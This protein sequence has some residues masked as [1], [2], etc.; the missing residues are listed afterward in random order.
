MPRK[1]LNVVG[2]FAGIGGI[3]QGFKNAEFIPLIANEID[4]YAVK[5]YSEFHDH[6]VLHLDIKD[7]NKATILSALQESGLSSNDLEG[8]ILTGGFPCQP[9]SIS[10]K[11]GGMTIQNGRLFYEIIRIAQYH[12][13]IVL[14]LE[15]VKNILSIEHGDVI[16]TIEQKIDEIGYKMYKHVLNASL[17]GVPQ[18]RERVYFVCIRKDLKEDIKLKYSPPKETNKKIYL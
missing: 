6:P 8:A 15:N 4:E 2:L 11:M 1:N 3:E 17:F 12:K 18:A 14:L 5:T 13:P 10:G 16:K 9:F 7:F